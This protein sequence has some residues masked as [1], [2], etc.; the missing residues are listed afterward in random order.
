MYQTNKTM[1]A[2]AINSPATKTNTHYS[3]GKPTGG[4]VQIQGETLYVD[5]NVIADLLGR[6]HRNLM[7]DL[8]KL[9][10]N[11]VINALSLERITYPDSRGRSQF[12]WR[13]SEPN[14]LV[15]MPYLGGKKSAQGQVKLVDEFL[16]M[17]TQLRRIT[18]RQLSLAWNQARLSGK[19]ERRGLT[20]AVQ[21][22]AHRP[23][24]RG[25]STTPVLHW[26]MSATKTVT[27][28]VF[29]LDQNEKCENIRDRLTAKQLNRL[30]MAEDTPPHRLPTPPALAT[31]S[32]TSPP[33]G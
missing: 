9:T 22:L 19:T 32:H 7:R 15:L 26:E 6:P 8:D 16:R 13:L 25:D 30:A 29:V 10:R 24:T 28:A 20:D 21:A 1:A 23:Y 11:G 12:G 18:I 3:I 2:T 33:P 17:R 14:A 31:T 4:M 27:A 5:S